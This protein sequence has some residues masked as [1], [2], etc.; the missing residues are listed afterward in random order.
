VARK[1]L[2]RTGSVNQKPG[3]VEDSKFLLV[4]NL[5]EKST[6]QIWV[7]KM[8]KKNDMKK[9]TKKKT[10]ISR[11]KFI[12]A[13]A[14]AT[15]VFNIVPRHVL[16]GANFTSPSEVI[17]MAGIG[18]GSHASFF[19]PG[20]INETGSKMVALCDVDTEFPKLPVIRASGGAHYDGVYQTYPENEVPRFQDYNEMLERN[21]LDIDAVLVATPDHQHMPVTMAAFRKDKHVYCEKDLGVNIYSVREATQFAKSNN[22][23]TQMGIGNHGRVEM[24]R[25]AEAIQTGVIGDVTEVNVWCDDEYVAKSTSTW[26]PRTVGKAWKTR[27]NSDLQLPAYNGS[28]PAGFDWEAWLG[29]AKDHPYAGPGKY[30]HR[31]WRDWW[32]FGGGRIADIGCHAMDW[33]FF[34]LN[35]KYPL[36]VEAEGRFEAGDERAADW[37]KVK[38]D[39]PARENMQPVTVNWYDGN[40]RPDNY[41]YIQKELNDNSGDT[42]GWA[43]ASMFIGTEGILVAQFYPTRWKLYPLKRGSNKYANFNYNKRLSIFPYSKGHY[44]EFTTGIKAGDPSITQCGFDYSG[45][46]SETVLLGIAAYRTGKKLEWDPRNL[47]AIGT[48]EADQFLKGEYRA[49]WVLPSPVLPDNNYPARESI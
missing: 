36:S 35:L 43:R 14:A 49:G 5:T 25:I 7:N 4:G 2:L 22:R 48:P 3:K 33:V 10:D 31:N 24:R 38:W 40:T 28:P 6:T 12:G 13:A 15:S 29:P 39:F 42:D 47:K 1:K 41:Q 34:A 37:L 27:A 20:M 45:P 32:D 23:V 46:L 30:H 18:C 9:T 11:R 44:R 8:R 17:R 19:F 16:G 21:D 26:P